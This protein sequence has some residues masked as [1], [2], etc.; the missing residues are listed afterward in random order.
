MIRLSTGLRNRWLGNKESLRDIFNFGCAKLDIYASTSIPVSAD[1][2]VVGTL[3]NT[4]TNASATVRVA[5]RIRITPVIGTSAFA[6]TVWNVV[7][8]GT[9][10]SFTDD[11]V[12]TPARVCTGLFNALRAASGAVAV[13]TPPCVMNN[14]DIFQRFIFTDNAGTL[15]IASSVAGISFDLTVH[16]SGAGAGTGA[17]A[18]S[19]ITADAYG[20]QFE[21]FLDITNA[22]LEKL[23]TQTWSGRAVASGVAVY[24]R[25]VLDSDTGV[26][27][28]TQPRIQGQ[29]AVAGGAFNLTSL[30]II[31]GTTST[32]SSFAITFPESRA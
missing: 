27:S 12:S 18:T 19:V 10:I 1:H 30:D 17:M 14:P 2:A 6:S 28:I 3:L 21:P 4:I 20:L 26:I 13:T 7:L 8:N 5:Q 16:V 22:V 11:A 9:T 31:A 29:V 24:G 25:L 32:V 23:V 15:D